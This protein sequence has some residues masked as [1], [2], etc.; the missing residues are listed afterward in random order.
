MK[1][2]S[3]S[4]FAIRQGWSLQYVGKLVG[5]GKIDPEQAMAAIKAQPEPSN[6]LRTQGKSETPLPSAPTDSRQAVDF[7]TAR[8]MREAFKAKMEYEEKAGKLTEEAPNR[9]L[10][11]TGANSAAGLR[12]IPARFLFTDDVDG[13]GSPINLAIK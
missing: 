11:F 8:N 1:L 4:E 6:E 3:Q 10:I 13:E 2:L 7:V 9:V 5:S 12:C